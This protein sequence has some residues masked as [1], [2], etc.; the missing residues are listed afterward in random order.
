MVQNLTGSYLNYYLATSFSIIFFNSVSFG[1]AAPELSDEEMTPLELSAAIPFPSSI[2]VSSSCSIVLQY[3]LRSLTWWHESNELNNIVAI[4][5]Q[6]RRFKR[7]C[8]E[9]N[10]ASIPD[11]PK[12]QRIDLHE[13][14]H[15]QLLY[16]AS[17][18][19]YKI[20]V[21]EYDITLGVLNQSR[22][23]HRYF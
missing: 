2:E 22:C 10:D 6:T 8:A 11:N 14:T 16:G 7:R 1:D 4:C 17:I 20:N 21:R 3:F 18:K 9:S 13:F 15:R 23:D 12:H 5:I 19:S